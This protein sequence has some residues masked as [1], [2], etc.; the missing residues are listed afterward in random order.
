MSLS[1]AAPGDPEPFRHAQDW[2]DHVHAGRIA[3]NPGT[4]SAQ[5]ARHIRNELLVLGEIR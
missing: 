2:L 3:A 5:L 1:I 4:T